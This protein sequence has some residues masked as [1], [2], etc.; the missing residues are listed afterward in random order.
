MYC[1]K[2]VCWLQ[3][4][5]KIPAITDSTTF[6]SGFLEKDS[7]H[8][9][10]G[11]RIVHNVGL[12]LQKLSIISSVDHLNLQRWSTLFPSPKSDLLDEDTDKVSSLFTLI[13]LLATSRCTK[14]LSFII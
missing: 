12:V 13:P 7:L 3:F 6:L 5:N 8:S 2:F 14:H 4:L 1:N 10:L 11:S 9:K